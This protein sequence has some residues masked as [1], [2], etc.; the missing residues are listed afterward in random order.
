MIGDGSQRN[1]FPLCIDTLNTFN[2]RLPPGLLNLFTDAEGTENA[3][4][5][6]SSYWVY[7]HVISLPATWI[8]TVVVLL[9]AILPD[10]AIRVIRK[11]WVGIRHELEVY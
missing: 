5:D 9:V 1:N 8:M 7:Y 3:P 6:P 11:H 2:P 4:L 10:V